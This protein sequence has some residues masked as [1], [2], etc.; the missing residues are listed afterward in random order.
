[1]V[2]TYV[3]YSLMIVLVSNSYIQLLSA[4]FVRKYFKGGT[5]MDIV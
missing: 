1:M 2:R 5:N 4:E 3:I